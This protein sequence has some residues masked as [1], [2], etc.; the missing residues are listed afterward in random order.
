[1]QRQMFLKMREPHKLLQGSGA[2]L[3]DRPEFHVIVHKG[4]DLL[5][6][7]VGEA[8]SPADGLGHAHTDF[9]V[10]VETNP[11]PRLRGGLERWWLANIVQKNPPGES[12]GSVLGKPLEHQ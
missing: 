4:K 9:D 7:L 3:L 12:W 2:H 8:Q 6:V 10:V 5:G 1:M 11:V